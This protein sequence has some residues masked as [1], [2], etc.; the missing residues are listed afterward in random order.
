[1]DFTPAG[2]PVSLRF[3]F[4]EYTL[5]QLD[6]I[7]HA[8]TI[9]ERTLAYGNRAELRW[10]FDTYGA[11]RLI[12]WLQQDGWRSLP[13]RRLNLWTTYFNLAQAPKRRGLWPY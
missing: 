5:E 13:K 3:A 8:F 9:I 2:I 1:M 6:P 10:L 7:A 11:P 4:Q 12:D